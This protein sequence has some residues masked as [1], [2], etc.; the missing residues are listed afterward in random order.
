MLTSL[1]EL[2]PVDFLPE[3]NSLEHCHHIGIV[4]HLVGVGVDDGLGA[5]DLSAFELAAHTTNA[6][7]AATVIVLSLN[8]EE[9][10]SQRF[11]VDGA[12]VVG[13]G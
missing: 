10:E 8:G 3:A 12:A 13:G 2:R 9:F 1:A 6:A 11:G 5:V 4:A 7:D